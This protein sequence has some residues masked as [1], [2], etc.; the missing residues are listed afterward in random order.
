MP[1]GHISAV[2]GHDIHHCLAHFTASKT[3]KSIDYQYGDWLKVDSGQSKSPPRRSKDSP[4]RATSMGSFD[5]QAKERS[6][7]HDATM[8]LTRAQ[9]SMECRKSQNG[10]LGIGDVAPDILEQISEDDAA[11][12][13]NKDTPIMILPL[14]GD[15]I[16]NLN[17]DSNVV[18]STV[19][20]VLGHMDLKPNK[21][22]SM[23][24]R[25]VRMDVGP[26]DIANNIIK[27]M[28]GKRG[29][30]DVLVEDCNRE[31]EA[32]SHKCSKVDVEDD[33]SA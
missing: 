3:E 25:M 20:L 9:T 33:K 27:P 4:P 1:L 6:E 16:P 14:Y 7:V 11:Q 28:M 23:W 21:P 5:D 2:L 19:N 24:T 31:T 32:G 22:K 29:L 8:A 26:S 13:S 12:D 30:G 17:R 10:N 18:S 15:L